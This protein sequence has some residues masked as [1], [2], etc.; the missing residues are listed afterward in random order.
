[1][2][3]PKR[4]LLVN[5]RILRKKRNLL[6]SFKRL[7]KGLLGTKKP[8]NRAGFRKKELPLMKF[9]LYVVDFLCEIGVVTK[10]VLNT[11]YG[12]NNRRMVSSAKIKTDGF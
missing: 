11:F 1:M 8:A 5:K 9:C 6:T 12:V 2:Q 4:M 7:L 3:T 10:A